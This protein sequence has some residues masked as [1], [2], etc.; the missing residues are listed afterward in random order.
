M[1]VVAF[2]KE[3][4]KKSE[5]IGSIIFLL[6]DFDGSYNSSGKFAGRSIDV[7]IVRNHGFCMAIFIRGLQ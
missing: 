5:L 2:E 1:L 3:G 7:G 4:C 6:F